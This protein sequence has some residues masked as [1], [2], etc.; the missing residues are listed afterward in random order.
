MGVVEEAKVHTMLEDKAL[1]SRVVQA[2][3]EDP[4]VLSK[5]GKDVSDELEDLLQDDPTFR[6]KVVEAATTNSQFKTQVV[7]N[8]VQ[9]T[10]H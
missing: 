10:S 3:G 8:V 1:V 6:E 5:L 2:M 4:T 9:E 7:R